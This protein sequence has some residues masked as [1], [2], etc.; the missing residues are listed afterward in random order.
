[1]AKVDLGNTNIGEIIAKYPSTVN[2]M[3]AHGLPCVGCHVNPHETLHQGTVGHG[4]GEEQYDS[5]IKDMEKAV[6]ESKGKGPVKIIAKGVLLTP[7]AATK[8]RELMKAEDKTGWGIR[9]EPVPG[10]CCQDFQMDFDKAPNAKDAVFEQHTI[11]IF[12]QKD[13]ADKIDGTII[14]FRKGPDGDNFIMRNPLA[15]AACTCGKGH[16]H[17]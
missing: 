7:T 12:Y 11:S 5:L 9:V 10:G 15:K 4:W 1:M 16:D 8:L 13:L 2:V 17:H 6:K 14:D 3:L